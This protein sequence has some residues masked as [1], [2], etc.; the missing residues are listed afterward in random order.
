[1]HRETDF[2]SLWADIPHYQ[3]SKTASELAAWLFAAQTPVDRELVAAMLMPPA[4]GA[5]AVKGGEWLG[6][7]I[8][9][10]RSLVRGGGLA[11]LEVVTVNPSFVLGPILLPKHSG[12]VGSTADI[13]TEQV[14]WGRAPRGTPTTPIRG[15]A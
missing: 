12:Y 11:P 13:V 9:E 6:A 3:R 1:M 14:R 2:S 8:E 5:R 15:R 4:D 7:K 10:I